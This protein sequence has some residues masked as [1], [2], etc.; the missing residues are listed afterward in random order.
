VTTGVPIYLVSACSSGEE[1]VAAFRRYADRNGVF[2]PI[3]DP[4]PVGKRGRFALTLRDGGVMIEGDG[5]VISSARTASVLHGRIGMTIRFSELDEPSKILLVELE[6]ARLAAKPPPPSV[7]P[8]PAEVPAEPRPTPPPPSARVDASSTLAQCVVIGDVA[9]LANAEAR[10]P[11]KAG[12]K[13]VVPAIPP[14]GQRPRTP[15]SPPELRPKTP[16]VP[17]PA[18]IPG[19]A[20]VAVP[21]PSA[22]PSAATDL[23]APET[24]KPGALSAT[25]TAVKPAPGAFSET[26]PAIQLADLKA[27]L[28]HAVAEDA[29]EPT[30][31]QAPIP[32]P[33]EPEP[34]PE[35]PA[36]RSTTLG[37][38]PIPRQPVAP[39]V[40]EPTDLTTM[41]I[42]E[43]APRTTTIGVAVG[44]HVLPA[45]VAENRERAGDAVVPEPPIAATDE[46]RPGPLHPLEDTSGDWTIDPRSGLAAREHGAPPARDPS[47][48]WTLAL[49]DA[50]AAAAPAGGVATSPPPGPPHTTTT[51]ET[52]AMAPPPVEPVDE[53]K[54]QVDPTLI[55][56]LTPLP[57]EPPESLAS[58]SVPLAV[59]HPQAGPSPAAYYTPPPGTIPPIAPLA[60]AAIASAT[61]PT[62]AYQNAQLGRRVVTDGGT[63]FFR[64]TG[65]QVPI[66]DSTSMVSAPRSK[67]I[68]VIAIS[69]VLVVAA[70]AV[71]LVMFA[72]GD[73]PARPDETSASAVAS[74]PIAADAADATEPHATDQVQPE[75][76]DATVE[77][78]PPPPPP[79]DAAVLEC[80]VDVAS[81][82]TGAE[83]VSNKQVLGMTPAKLPLP[84]GA[85]IKLVL[86]KARFAAVARTVVPTEQGAKLKLALARPTY[87]VKVSSQPAGATVTADGKPL[88]VTPTTIKLP[89]FEPATLTLSKAGYASETLKITPRQNN[90]AIQAK[91]KK[92]G[93]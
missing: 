7:P 62:L 44:A 69:A 85:P 40:D 63:G 46:R 80:F 57:P 18:A 83:I 26:M 74:D 90:Q 43:P 23:S 47:G 60:P 30:A 73:R 29:D 8:R 67:R 22:P 78:P 77:D 52:R 70:G 50:T 75:A 37:V 81:T 5:E 71:V 14:V 61:S 39:E 4:I 54:V 48:D 27:D 88:G 82:P 9:A 32:T 87:A 65:E 86:R 84:C 13:F 2:V 93:R 38:A 11:P 28:A 15:S 35:R 31:T 10:P 55:E 51:G 20:A 59:A 49:N 36:P 21:V 16:S 76:T 66:E 91:L 17:P 72:S 12:P 1:F 68:L 79:V 6:R 92:R 64:D 53:P 42:A 41:P 33:P 24:A 19:P 56:P 58:A 45:A 89:G 3:T 34:E 25:L